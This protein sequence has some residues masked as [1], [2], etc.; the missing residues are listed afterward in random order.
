MIS[1]TDLVCA[2]ASKVKLL[3]PLMMCHADVEKSLVIEM[4]YLLVIIL[5]VQIL[6][7]ILI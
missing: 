7:Y 3:L 5:V 6:E 1:K 4:M 2:A